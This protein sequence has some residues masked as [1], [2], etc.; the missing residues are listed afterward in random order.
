MIAVSAKVHAHPELS[1]GIIKSVSQM[2][3]PLFLNVCMCCYNEYD[4]N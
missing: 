4:I 2:H 3:A 1:V